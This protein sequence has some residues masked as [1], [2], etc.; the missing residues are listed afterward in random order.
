MQLF[1]MQSKSVVMDAARLAWLNDKVHQAR[2]GVRGVGSCVGS[3]RLHRLLQGQR[4]Q[5]VI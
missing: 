4:R 3:H 1:C 5:R 2:I